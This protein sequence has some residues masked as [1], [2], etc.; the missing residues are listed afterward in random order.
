MGIGT[1]YEKPLTRREDLLAIISNISPVDT[2]LFTMAAKRKATNTTHSWIKETLEA[3]TVGGEID[4]ADTSFSSYTYNPGDRVNNYTH[5]MKEIWGL[6][7]GEAETSAAD[8]KTMKAREIWRKTRQLSRK[9]ELNLIQSTAAAGNGTS[10]ARTMMGLDEFLTTNVLDNSGTARDLTETVLLDG[11]QLVWEQGATPEIVLCH[12]YTKRQIS[13]FT[14]NTKNVNADAKK[15]VNVVDV[16]ESPFGT[17]TIK[18]ER[19]VP[20]TAN[21]TTLYAGQKDLIGVAFRRKPKNVDLAKTGDSTKGH[22][23]TELTLEVLN[24]AGWVKI[25]DLNAV[26]VV[27]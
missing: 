3:P 15:L 12:A 4:G 6:A 22:V 2:P 5:I 26:Y 9:I 17:V 13:G 24:E 11:L 27:P 14:S 20:N 21:N 1:G 18:I 25:E 8:G 23:I 19:Y 16:Y 7:D 10:V